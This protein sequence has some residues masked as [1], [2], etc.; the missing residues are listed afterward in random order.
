MRIVKCARKQRADRSK[1]IKVD[2]SRGDIPQYNVETES[3][4]LLDMFR[5][6][7]TDSDRSTHIELASTMNTFENT[8]TSI[9]I[10]I[11]HCA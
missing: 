5:V 11:A 2:V 1:V 8:M 9:Y 7:L 10:Y 4:I 3:Y 6:Y